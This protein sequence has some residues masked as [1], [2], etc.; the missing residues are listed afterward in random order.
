MKIIGV[1]G[2]RKRDTSAAFKKIK[3]KFFEVYEEILPVQPTAN[4]QYLFKM[5]LVTRVSG[6]EPVWMYNDDNK[7]GEWLDIWDWGEIELQDNKYN[8]VR[9]EVVI[10]ISFATDD[11]VGAPV[12]G[13]ITTKRWRMMTSAEREYM[14]KVKDWLSGTG[15]TLYSHTHRRPGGV[16]QR[17]HPG[18][19]AGCRM[20]C[21]LCPAGARHH[22]Y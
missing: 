2:T 8:G 6:Q 14:Y 5:D 10:D 12:A 11:G 20:L 7:F 16:E 13:T 4:G 17:L 1:I 21:G 18:A 3:E 9:E 22:T 15:G 19:A